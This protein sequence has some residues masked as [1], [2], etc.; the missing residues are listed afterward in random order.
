MNKNVKPGNLDPQSGMRGYRLWSSKSQGSTVNLSPLLLSVMIAGLLDSFAF[1]LEGREVQNREISQLEVQVCDVT[2]E[3]GCF[4]LQI[5][6][7]LAPEES[8][9]HKFQEYLTLLL[10]E[11]G[12]SKEI[13]IVKALRFNFLDL[14]PIPKPSESGPEAQTNW[15]PKRRVKLGYAEEP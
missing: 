4:L 3:E 15:F 14:P 11:G 6:S 13:S 9:P 12:H 5:G 2:D 8:V 10:G 7:G 1:H